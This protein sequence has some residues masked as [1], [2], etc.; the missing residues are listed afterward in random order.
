MH[1]NIY[2]ENDFDLK[3]INPFKSLFYSDEKNIKTG[4]YIKWIQELIINPDS[5]MATYGSLCRKGNCF[6]KIQI[7][8]ITN[9][10]NNPFKVLINLDSKITSALTHLD[11]STD[12]ECIVCNCLFIKKL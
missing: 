3:I 1:G 4:K 11:W 2:Y 10:F 5:T 12:N 9:Y 8:S 6:C 7:L